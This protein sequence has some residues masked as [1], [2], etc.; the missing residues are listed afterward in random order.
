MHC[1]PLNPQALWDQF[2]GHLCDDLRQRIISLFDV[3][4]PTEEQVCD[5]GLYLINDILSRNGKNLSNFPPMPLPERNWD[6]IQGNP[7]I[8]EELNYDRDQLQDFVAAGV[9]TLN[10]DQKV[11]YDKVTESCNLGDGIS[12]FVHNAGRYGKTY[13]RIRVI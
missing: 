4:D 13:V 9:T 7:L 11:V 5:Y 2:K 10:H 8:F 3:L 1:S 12:Y 6:V